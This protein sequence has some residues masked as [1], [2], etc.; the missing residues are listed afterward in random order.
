[1]CQHTHCDLTTIVEQQQ[2]LAI[3]TACWLKAG[4]RSSRGTPLPK[5]SMARRVRT[6]GRAVR[7]S[8]I[9]YSAHQLDAAAAYATRFL[10][11][12]WFGGRFESD[13]E[14][15]MVRLLIGIFL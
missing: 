11:R 6:G 13:A 9:A 15:Y 12:R 3:G 5:K 10:N 1:M 8:P 14:A 7:Q 2:T 4:R